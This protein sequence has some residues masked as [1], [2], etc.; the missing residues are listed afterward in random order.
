MAI[1]IPGI[2]TYGNGYGYGNGN[3]QNMWVNRQRRNSDPTGRQSQQCQICGRSNHTAATCYHRYSGRPEP[4]QGFAHNRT[5]PDNMYNGY[6]SQSYANVVQ[7]K[8]IRSP[9][10]GWLPN[11]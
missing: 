1:H 3:R 5:Q 6:G 4:T 11:R 8:S 10:T 2:I 7:S 9:S